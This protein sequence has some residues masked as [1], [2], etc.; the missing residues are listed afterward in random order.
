MSRSDSGKEGR[1]G[2][3]EGRKPSREREQLPR[4]LREVK[5]LKGGP[6]SLQRKEKMRLE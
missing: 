3:G 5:K 4:R 6:C 1:G 2:W